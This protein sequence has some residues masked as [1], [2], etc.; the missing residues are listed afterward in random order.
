[1]VSGLD[2]ADKISRGKVRGERPVDPAKLI[3]VTIERVGSAP[4]K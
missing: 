1:V 3:R 4:K 2:V